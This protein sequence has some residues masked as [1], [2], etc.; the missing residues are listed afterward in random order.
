MCET[1]KC[2]SEQQR[3]E[4]LIGLAYVMPPR[5]QQGERGWIQPICDRLNVQRGKRSSSLG[6]RARAS[7]QSV[8]RR[9]EFD[10]DIQK[11]LEPLLEG[12]TAL[13]DGYECEI[14]QIGGNYQD[15]GEEGPPCKIMFKAQGFTQQYDYDCMFGK[16]QGSARLQRPP[17]TLSPDARVVRHAA[18]S[19]KHRLLVKE[20]VYEVCSESP[21]KRD[22]MRKH[23][24]PRVWEQ[25]QALILTPCR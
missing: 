6:A 1:K 7:D 16:R 15:Y 21:C 2:K 10:Q 11:Q 17:P 9:A 14:T 23:V 20:H 12:D 3:K 25:R 5:M 18:V 24:A 8:D 19:A 4:Y 13:S 22:A